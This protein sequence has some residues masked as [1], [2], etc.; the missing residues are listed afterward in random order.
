MTNQVLN[1]SMTN[2]ITV[3]DDGTTLTVAE[4]KLLIQT[5]VNDAVSKHVCRIKAPDSVIAEIPDMMNAIK[6]IGDGDISKGI[7]LIQDDHRFMTSL[8]CNVDKLAF[9]IANF[10]ILA[11]VGGLLSALYVGVKHYLKMG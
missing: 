10:M 8:R 4:L 3:E 7:M 11:L 2:T 1:Q 9:K 6:H 5:S